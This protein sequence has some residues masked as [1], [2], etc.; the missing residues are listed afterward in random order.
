MR[1]AELFD[2]LRA[3]ALAAAAAEGLRLRF[4]PAAGPRCPTRSCWAVECAISSM[5]R[6]RSRPAAASGG[7]GE[8][9]RVPRGGSE[10][11]GCRKSALRGVSSIGGGKSFSGWRC[12]LRVVGVGTGCGAGRGAAQVAHYSALRVP[13]SVT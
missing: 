11:V 1:L 9:P 7:G 12:R 10:S 6:S 2:S 5:T 13:E 3:G 8:G 4:A